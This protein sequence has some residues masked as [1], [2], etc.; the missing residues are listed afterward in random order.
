[1][2]RVLILRTLMVLSAPVVFAMFWLTGG[3]EWRREFWESGVR[4]WRAE[5]PRSL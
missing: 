3:T 5:R 2:I 4:L 1:M